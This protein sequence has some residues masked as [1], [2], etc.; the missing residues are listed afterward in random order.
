[1]LIPTLALILLLNLCPLRNEIQRIII[2]MSMSP[3]LS[4]YR[5]AINPNLS[6]YRITTQLD[7]HRRNVL[8]IRS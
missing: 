7:K 2:V 3:N 6:S 4:F 1:M 8:L 5:I